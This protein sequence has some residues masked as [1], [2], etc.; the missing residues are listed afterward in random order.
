MKAT[1]HLLAIALTFAMA[2]PLSAQTKPAVT[3]HMHATGQS[4]APSTIDVV[5]GSEAAVAVIDAFGKALVAADF[6]TV[7]A[8]LDPAVIILETGG[9]ERSR[10]E[11][12]SHHA[13]SDARFLAGSHS[14]LSRRIARID[15]DTVWVASES[16]LHANKDGKPMTMLGTETMVLNKTPAGWKI[17]HIHWSSRPKK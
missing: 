3:G 13:R 4:A 8:L 9:A 5:P 6:K 10:N 14:T 15:G 1:T 16:E 11:Y 2:S 12:V 17:V 7:E